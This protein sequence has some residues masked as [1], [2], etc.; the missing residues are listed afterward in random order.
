MKEE[1]V[2]NKS[3]GAASSNDEFPLVRIA[4]NTKDS[5]KEWIA[6]NRATF[7]AELINHGAVLFRGFSIDT[8][9]KFEDLM[10]EVTPQNLEYGFRSSPRYSIGNGVYVSTT[11]PADE[12]IL[13][14]SEGS[15]APVH[16]EHIVFCCIIPAETGGETPIADNRKVLTFLSEETRKK[17]ESRGV[18][19]VRTLDKFV[20]LPWQ[21]VFQTEDKSEVEKECKEKGIE[22]EWINDD[23]LKMAWTKKGVWEHPVSGE[24]IWFNHACFFNKHSMDPDM[25]EFFEMQNSLP[26]NT[27]FGD[28]SEISKE[29]ILEIHKAYKTT[30]TEFPW[31]KG[32]VLFVDNM[33]AAHARNPYTG[34][35]KIIVSIY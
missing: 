30:S 25:M 10:K 26:Y 8:V 33:I 22:F 29:E 31:E 20:G 21:E 27:F 28:G 9:E 35:R 2:L 17:F 19:Y 18:K 16:P 11:H 23:K 34:D 12:N 14:H 3:N 4:E 32:D 6:G 7:E 24:S 5:L 13:M 1:T 15:Y